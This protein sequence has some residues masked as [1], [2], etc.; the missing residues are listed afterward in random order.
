MTEHNMDH[1][2]F[3][4]TVANDDVAVLRRKESTY[5]GS[6]KRAGGR[7]AWFMARRNID[8][9]LEMMKKPE[10]LP[11]FNLQNVEDTIAAI[12]SAPGNGKGSLEVQFP[13][14]REAT[15]AILT[16][17]KRC[18]TAENIFAKIREEPSGND[19]TVLAV[20]RDLR[21]YLMLVEAE[22]MARQVVKP[23]IVEKLVP[24]MEEQKPY[25]PEDGG[26]HA[27]LFPWQR[28]NLPGD[29]KIR[30]FYSHVAPKVWRLEPFVKSEKIPR[31]IAH[32]YHFTTVSPSCDWILR[33]DQVPEEL[34]DCYSRVQRELNNK[35]W[36]EHQQFF[37][38]DRDTAD[39]KYKL[40]PA[41]AAWGRDD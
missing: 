35:E 21:R 11:I 37:L 17:L 34:R 29:F 39:G 41:Y 27:S 31:E 28:E 26:Q 3:L 19:G 22:M 6:W 14:T 15:C 24:R 13:G 18:Y 1:M 7:S 8:R 36:S 12:S 4:E 25:T 20:I 23:E 38:Y 33:I 2:K 16:H 5:Q 30:E 32:C 10:D 40:I 9:L